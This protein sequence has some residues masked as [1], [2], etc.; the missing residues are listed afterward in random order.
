MIGRI[1]VKLHIKCCILNIEA[2][3]IVIL[4]M[5]I[6]LCIFHYKPMADNDVPG[7]GLYG[8]HGHDKEDYDT[9]LLTKYESFGTCGFGEEFFLVFPIARIWELSVAL[10]TI[11][12]L[13]SARKPNTI[14]PPT[15]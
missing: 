1:Y 13:Q 9:L 14:N 6:F 15:H 10:E 3:G 11:L 4:E 5:K 7:R 8:P 2:L 12:L